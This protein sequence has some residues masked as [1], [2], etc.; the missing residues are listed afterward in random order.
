[1]KFCIDQ[2]VKVIKDAGLDP[3]IN[4]ILVASGVMA[5]YKIRNCNDIDIVVDEDT[6]TKLKQSDNFKFSRFKDGAPNLRSNNL[7]IF[8][9]WDQ[10]G[11]IESNFLDLFK[12]SKIVNGV[13]VL[14]LE[15]VR[16]WK[17]K[18]ARKKDLE[19]IK[20]IDDYFELN[21]T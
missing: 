14:N 9:K 16:G 13:R 18:K 6:F 12:D 3:E 17:L 1:M 20:L 5:A 8:I 19:D 21:L 2:V 4:V 11:N 10:P 15:R 7:D